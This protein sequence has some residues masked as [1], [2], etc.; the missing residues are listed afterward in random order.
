[1]ALETLRT[2]WIGLMSHRLRTALT[3]LG[4]TIGIASVIVLVAVGKGSSDAV[5]ESID[6]LGSNTLT[7][8][9]SSGV[10]T[11]GAAATAVTLE[12]ADVE[13]LEDE[14]RAPAIASVS[15]V[16]TASGA[17]LTYGESSYEPGEFV[18]TTPS[19]AEAKNLELE[20]GTFFTKAQVKER[21][22]VAVIGPEVA[23]ELFA[24][25][26]PVGK[27]MQ[28]NGVNYE[29]IGVTKSKGSSG[30]TSQDDGVVAPLTA[31]E[32]TLAG[33]GELSSITVLATG[34]DTVEAAE[35]QITAIL[36]E[37]HEISE[38]INV[39][40]QSSIIE[41]SSSSESVFTTLLTWVA[42]ISLLVGGIGVMN[43]MLVS[44]TERTRE[45]GI[46]KA[47]G[48]RRGDI[49]AQFLTEALLVS[50]MGGL[51]GIAV[52]V[53]GSQFRI[54]GVQPAV[55]GYSVLLAA[56]ASLGS[57]LFFGTYPAMRAARLRPIEALRFE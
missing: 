42:A 4:I 45:I 48:A 51:L 22:R 33:Y 46:R 5:K 41:A 28:V 27:T 50:A 20:S 1:M 14:E 40:N 34:T 52:G 3:V 23:S 39:T 6:A 44:V 35:A 55:A 21:A 13:A 26:S 11:V 7:V 47:I 38:G 24:G 17:E 43:I 10:S 32:D 54:A 37:R 31:V 56:G 49:M 25:T 29:V 15:P 53:I 30:V 16:V 9:A 36:D 2:A 12:K 18:G 19:Y 57:G 8:S